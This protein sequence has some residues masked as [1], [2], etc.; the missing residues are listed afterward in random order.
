[1]R[2]R[3][4]LALSLALLAAGCARGKPRSDSPDGGRVELS[5]GEDV[6]PVYPREGVKPHPLAE[7]LCGALHTLPRER[8]VACCG[9][10]PGINFVSECVRMLSAAL[11]DGAVTVDAA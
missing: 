4:P 3:P 7:R 9:G 11:R 1:M 8:Q 6:R 10:P 5:V 2:T